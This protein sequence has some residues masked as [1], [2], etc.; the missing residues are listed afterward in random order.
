M[1]WKQAQTVCA[2]FHTVQTSTAVTINEAFYHVRGT[3]NL[4]NYADRNRSGR[5]EYERRKLI[6]YFQKYDM[7]CMH[8]A[9]SKTKCT[10]TRRYFKCSSV[11]EGYLSTYVRAY[12]PGYYTYMNLKHTHT[13]HAHTHMIIRHTDMHMII[14]YT[15]SHTHTYAKIVTN[16]SFILCSACRAA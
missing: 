1:V 2:C 15:V 9:A 13:L 6:I 5:E 7:E 3:Y 14:K 16:C 11:N 12:T 8:I 10:S 4:V